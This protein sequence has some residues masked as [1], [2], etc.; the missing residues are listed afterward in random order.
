M[1]AEEGNADFFN[2]KLGIINFSKRRFVTEII[3]DIQRFQD[4]FY[5]L[6]EEPKIKV[7]MS[8]I[9]ECIFPLIS[10]TVLFNMFNFV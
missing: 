5:C 7:Y 10:L 2:E 6:K 9:P 4:K 3:E 8:F 1:H